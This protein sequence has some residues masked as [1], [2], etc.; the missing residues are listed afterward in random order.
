MNTLEFLESSAAKQKRIAFGKAPATEP[1]M[2]TSGDCITIMVAL[3]RDLAARTAGTARAH[4]VK[5]R[6]KI[7]QLLLAREAAAMANS[8]DERNAQ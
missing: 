6:K 7:R 8:S 3:D 5:T 4:A 2:L 1:A